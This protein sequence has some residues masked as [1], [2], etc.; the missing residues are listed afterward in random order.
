MNSR[1]GDALKKVEGKQAD[2][3]AGGATFQLKGRKVTL[4]E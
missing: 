3:R 4:H 1:Q 2:S